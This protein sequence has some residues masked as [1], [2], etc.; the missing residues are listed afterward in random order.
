MQIAQKH[1]TKKHR[2]MERDGVKQMEGKEEDIETH[3]QKG[4]CFHSRSTG[5]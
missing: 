5:S 4:I 1:K 3:N 2:E